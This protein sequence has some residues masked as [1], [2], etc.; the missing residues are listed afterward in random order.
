MDAGLAITLQLFLATEPLLYLSESI[1]ALILTMSSFLVS[2]AM[3]WTML[4]DT[5]GTKAAKTVDM[6][7]ELLVQLTRVPYAAYLRTGLAGAGH[8][9]LSGIDAWRL[10][11]SLASMTEELLS[12]Q[13]EWWQAK[14]VLYFLGVGA[15]LLA[16]TLLKLGVWTVWT[17]ARAMVQI[18]RVTTT[19]VRPRRRHQ[20][21]LK[22]IAGSA[23]AVPP[24][25]RHVRPRPIARLH[26][27]S[28]NPLITTASPHI[29]HGRDSPSPTSSFRADFPH[30]MTGPIPRTKSAMMSALSQLDRLESRLDDDD[31]GER[32]SDTGDSQS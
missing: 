32:S 17:S 31:E 2:V 22:H 3:F 5:L 4:G 6:V 20:A 8:A 13:L 15:L 19:V 14:A 7:L 24:L 21:R 28:T 29:R 26:T 1:L 16:F 9:I 27:Q 30:D 10:G 12:T 23:T 25:S 18:V 11:H